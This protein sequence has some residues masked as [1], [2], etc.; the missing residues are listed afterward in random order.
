M[1]GLWQ[2]EGQLKTWRDTHPTSEIPPQPGTRSWQTQI[3]HVV[4]TDSYRQSHSWTHLFNT[5]PSVQRIRH[6]SASDAFRGKYVP[7]TPLL[8][9]ALC[10]ASKSSSDVPT[11]GSVSQFCISYLA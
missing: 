6:L 1:L 4:F 9:R 8:R 2:I 3:V 7:S 11:V 10:V 5:A